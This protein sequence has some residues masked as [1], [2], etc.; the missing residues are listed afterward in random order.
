MEGIRLQTKGVERAGRG[1]VPWQDTDT[2]R[3]VLEESGTGAA[4]KHKKEI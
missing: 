3:E 2:K 4:V 1:V